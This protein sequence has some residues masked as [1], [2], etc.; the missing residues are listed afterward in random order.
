MNYDT[1]T[2]TAFTATARIRYYAPR[3]AGA[4]VWSVAMLGLLIACLGYRA[5]ESGALFRSQFE[6]GYHASDVV[7]DV[8]LPELSELFDFN[9]PTPDAT[10]PEFAFN[11]TSPNAD[12][13]S[14]HIYPDVRE[15]VSAMAWNDLRKVGKALGYSIKTKTTLLTALTEETDLD[16]L[17]EAWS[18]VTQG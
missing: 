9:A 7:P 3:I 8:D 17:Y 6:T 12:A 4:W 5:Y 16:D 1:F 18:D 15:A 14:A 2:A 13:D 11:T 10:V